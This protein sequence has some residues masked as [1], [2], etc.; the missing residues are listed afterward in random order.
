[1][2]VVAHH[3]QL[4]MMQRNAGLQPGPNSAPGVMCSGMKAFHRST[5]NARRTEAPQTRVERMRRNDFMVGWE[6]AR[7]SRRAFTDRRCEGLAHPRS[8]VWSYGDSLYT[9]PAF[10][11]HQGYATVYCWCDDLTVS[12]IEV[13]AERFAGERLI[14]VALAQHAFRTW[15]QLGDLF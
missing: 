1:M 14:S 5:S 9:N 13:Q 8:L 4:P 15:G 10:L 3:Q 6:G 12:A 2:D 7:V 11:V